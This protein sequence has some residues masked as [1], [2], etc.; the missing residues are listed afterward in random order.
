MKAFAWLTAVVLVVIAIGVGASASSWNQ[1]IYGPSWGR[2]TIAFPAA[3]ATGSPLPPH[4]YES[5][6]IANGIQT[7]VY[8]WVGRATSRSGPIS[9][10]TVVRLVEHPFPGVALPGHV[11][12]DG[13]YTS[14]AGP[15]WGSG[16]GCQSQQYTFDTYVIWRVRVEMY[17]ANDKTTLTY[18]LLPSC[19]APYQGV[20]ALLATFQPVG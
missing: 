17:V 3:P 4:T 11:S 6:T 12:H 13:N 15:H 19:P 10:A 2:F 8:V 7:V 1:P 9:T 20:G 16:Q 18:G 14:V 5:R